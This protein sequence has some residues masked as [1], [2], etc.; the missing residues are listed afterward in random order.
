[1]RENVLYYIGNATSNNNSL[2]YKYEYR[3]L[4]DLNWQDNSGK[5]ISSLNNAIKMA[6]PTSYYFIN[7]TFWGVVEGIPNPGG[8]GTIDVPEGSIGFTVQD[9]PAGSPKAKIRV[10]VATDPAQDLNQTIMVSR[11]GSG[12]NQN[13][14][15]Q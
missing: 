7:T 1:M 12:T 6:A 13:Q 2:R 3:S 4:P 14:T 9:G 5:R 11:F 10:I 15:G 8:S